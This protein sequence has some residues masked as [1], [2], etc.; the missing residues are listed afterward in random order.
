MY[1][2]KLLS[3][4]LNSCASESRAKKGLF[5]KRRQN[6][7]GRR[8]VLWVVGFGFFP[9]CSACT[10]NSGMRS[11]WPS[12]ELLVWWEPRCVCRSRC[13]MTGVL[14]AMQ[15]RWVGENWSRGSSA[16]AAQRCRLAAWT[17][18]SRVETWWYVPVPWQR[19]SDSSASLSLTQSWRLLCPFHQECS[20]A[21]CWWLPSVSCW[22]VQLSP[23]KCYPSKWNFFFLQH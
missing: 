16:G 17:R 14:H 5:W 22:D 2:I 8:G 1:V 7:N 18:A 6:L 21:L 12:Q 11:R 19:N 20:S 13:A 4:L 9:L 15:R 23:W 10:E 3:C